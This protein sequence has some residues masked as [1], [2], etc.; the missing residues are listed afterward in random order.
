MIDRLTK[1]QR[2]IVKIQIFFPLC[3]TA[4]NCVITVTNCY[5]QSRFHCVHQTEIVLFFHSD[6]TIKKLTLCAF[7]RSEST[8]IRQ[9]MS[10]CSHSGYSHNQFSGLMADGV[11]GVAGV[12]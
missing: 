3:N 4:A 2:C 11:A 1:K 7:R 10:F 12:S 9:V 5:T 6:K 8:M